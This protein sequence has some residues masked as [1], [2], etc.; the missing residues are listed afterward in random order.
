[1]KEFF[2][3]HNPFQTFKPGS[4]YFF[5]AAKPR[6]Q[7]SY[8]TL[9]AGKGFSHIDHQGS[10]LFVVYTRGDGQIIIILLC[11][12]QNIDRATTKLEASLQQAAAWY[13]SC[14]NLE[15]EKT[16]GKKGTYHFLTEFNVLTPGLA[17]IHLEGIDKYI[18]SHPGG[19]KSFD[20]AQAMDEF[21]VSLGYND[22]QLE[23]GHYNMYA[24]NV[25][26]K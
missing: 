13:V 16:Y 25:L 2:F 1:M 7:A 5:H 26:L 6:F 3:C 19:V 8:S 23:M 24:A 10:H 9:D 22:L 11:I 12:A 20:K 14:Q 15:D 17:V 18:V 21:M 4:G